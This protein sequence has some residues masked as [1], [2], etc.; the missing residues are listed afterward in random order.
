[1]RSEY[2]GDILK[3]REMEDCI[4]ASKKYTKGAF[5][6]KVVHPMQG[7]EFPSRVITEYYEVYP[8]VEIDWE[9]PASLAWA[10]VWGD[11]PHIDVWF[12]YDYRTGVARCEIAGGTQSVKELIVGIPRLS[13]I[14][15]Q[16]EVVNGQRK[17]MDIPRPKLKE[18]HTRIY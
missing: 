13:G 12:H 18:E 11:T 9:M 10:L 17:P 4:R 2:Y 16:L 1:M 15:A 14:L 5:R 8:D 7:A 6:K 3:I